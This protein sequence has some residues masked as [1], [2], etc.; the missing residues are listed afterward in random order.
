M[1]EKLMKVNLWCFRLPA[2]S[3]TCPT[4]FCEGGYYDCPVPWELV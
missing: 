3:Q 4:E 1:N 2:H